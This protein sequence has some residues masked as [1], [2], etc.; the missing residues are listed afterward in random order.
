VALTL[1]QLLED[2]TAAR[3]VLQDQLFGVVVDRMLEPRQG[4]LVLDLTLHPLPE[5]DAD[6]YRPERCRISV[7][8]DGAVHA[9]PLGPARTWLHRNPSPLGPAFGYIAAELCLWYPGDPRSLRWEWPDGF[10]QYVTRVH[11]HVFF[12]EYNRRSGHWPTED[13][14]HG[15]AGASPHPIRTLTMN[16][17]AR[18]WAS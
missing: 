12:E 10:Q 15:D 18:R 2:P 6:G 8:P 4:G 14:P 13:A 9:F 16:R 17:E 3:R 11:R 5:L 1:T 7:R